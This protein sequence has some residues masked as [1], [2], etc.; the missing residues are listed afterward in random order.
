[1]PPSSYSAKRESLCIRKT[2]A[3]TCP[4]EE[5]SSGSLMVWT[6][7]ARIM[8][9]RGRAFEVQ[10]QVVSCSSSSGERRTVFSNYSSMKGGYPRAFVRVLVMMDV[11]EGCRLANEGDRPRTSIEPPKST[12]HKFVQCVDNPPRRTRYRVL[13]SKSRYTSHVTTRHASAH[14]WP[15]TILRRHPLPTTPDAGV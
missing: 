14:A 10:F 3:A 12:L 13:L 4:T 6:M 7:I 8:G 1:M 15:I 5:S 2:I 11:R 9:T